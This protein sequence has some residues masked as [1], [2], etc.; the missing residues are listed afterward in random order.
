MLSG[1]SSAV[2]AD[3]PSVLGPS[4]VPCVLCACG[5]AGAIA[6]INEYTL[7]ECGLALPFFRFPAQI[8]SVLSVS[9]LIYVD[10]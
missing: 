6:L 4:H 10:Q 5:L 9:A 8:Y 3:L 2:L 7:I 1:C